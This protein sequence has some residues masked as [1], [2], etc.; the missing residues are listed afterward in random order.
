[1][2]MTTSLYGTAFLWCKQLL[3]ISG[4]VT[5]LLLESQKEMGRCP[6]GFLA[7]RQSMTTV[8]WN[9]KPMIFYFF[10][11]SNGK[12]KKKKFLPAFSSQMGATWFSASTS[13]RGCYNSFITYDF[14]T[15]CSAYIWFKYLAWGA[16]LERTGLKQCKQMTSFLVPP[17]A[18]AQERK[19]L[20]LP[21]EGPRLP[22]PSIYTVVVMSPNLTTSL[23]AFV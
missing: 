6:A 23:P 2:P 12:G 11:F 13:L 7:S 22:V 19:T 18:L 10:S 20:P 14:I 4:T 17:C 9:R 3:F 16:L 15:Y 1:M 8:C 21:S 5:K